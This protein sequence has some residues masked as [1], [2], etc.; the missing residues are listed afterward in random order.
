MPYPSGPGWGRD[1]WVAGDLIAPALKPVR[2]LVDYPGMAEM[3]RVVYKLVAE[4]EHGTKEMEFV[5]EYDS[6]DDFE[7]VWAL[8][9]ADGRLD[10]LQD[11]SNTRTLTTQG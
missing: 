6:V 5:T 9:D 3:Y 2:D 7:D 10:L 4:T 11:P 1:E 8:V